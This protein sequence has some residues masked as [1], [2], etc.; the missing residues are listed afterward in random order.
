[1]DQSAKNLLD[2]HFA[3]GRTK[4]LTYLAGLSPA[5]LLHPMG[6]GTGV[7]IMDEYGEQYLDFNGGAQLPFGHRDADVANMALVQLQ[8]HTW[9]GDYGDYQDRLVADYA[10]LL[11][12][13]FPQKNGPPLKVM[14]TPSVYEARMTAAQICIC[15]PSQ[16]GYFLSLLTPEGIPREGGEV[17]DEVH[18]ARAQRL[19]IIADELDTGFGRTGSFCLFEQYHVTPD[20]IL[21]GS[22][23]TGGLPCNA[24]LAPGPLFETESFGQLIQHIAPTPNPIACAVGNAI[25]PR[26]NESLLAQVRNVAGTLAMDLAT[27]CE[28]FSD[29]LHSTPGVG[30][31]RTIKLN[32]PSRAE[33]FRRRCRHAGLLIQPNLRLSP[34]LTVTAQQVRIA[35][36]AVAAACIDME[37][38]V[39]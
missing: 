19:K 24:V 16:G 26:I 15:P 28:Q 29:V 36:D 22:A 12:D 10:A 39:L 13:R 18:R 5:S 9:F 8:E 3:T 20:V 31:I 2:I 27:V 30:L 1:M 14:F 32:A 37:E 11:S 6:R 4:C 33:D 21:L 17:Q 7:S 35:V 23:G 25:V 38:V 34:P